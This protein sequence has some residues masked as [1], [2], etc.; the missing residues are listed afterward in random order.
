MTGIIYKGLSQ[1]D[2][3]RRK[4]SILDF[5]L[6]RAKRIVPALLVLCSVLLAVGWF[7]QLSA[8]YRLLGMHSA[9]S[10]AFLS[11]IKYWKE[12]GYFDTESH[13]KWLLHTW[14]LSVEWQFYL[15]L[16]LLMLGLWKLKSGKT[17]M[18]ILFVVCSIASLLASIVVTKINPSAAFYLLPT[19]AW[20][21]LAGGLV[22]LLSDKI[23]LS[24]AKAKLVESTGI[25]FL[26]YSIFAYDGLVPWPSW[27]ALAPVIGSALVLLAARQESIWTGNYTAQ[28]LGTRSY[29]IYLWHWPIWVALGYMQN[30]QNPIYIALGLAA[31]LFLG[32]ISYLFIEEPFRKHLG[33]SSRVKT[34]TV[35]I[36]C[37]ATVSAIGITIR[38]NEGFLGRLS[39]A[40]TNI[41]KESLNFNP[42]RPECLGW[43]SHTSPS[44]LY[45]G[46]TIKA[47]VVGDSHS[48]TVITAVEDA[49]PNDSDGVIGISYS[50]CP[51]IFGVK[52]VGAEKNCIKFNEWVLSEITKLPTSVPVI[53]VNRLT[54]NIYGANETPSQKNT[55][56]I[57]FSTKHKDINDTFLSE[58][59]NNV[60]STTCLLAKTRKVYILRP[61]P[62]MG[63][64]VPK[65]MA[66]STMNGNESEV[67]I[68]LSDYNIR[69][70]FT[71]QTL[72]K[73]AQK[74]GV[75]ILDPAPYLCSND[76]CH[77]EVDGVPLY[78]DDNHLSE[79]G[80]RLLIPMFEK[81]L[82]EKV[83]AEN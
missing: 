53:I 19:R 5:Y 66:L 65:T 32:H 23:S 79:K 58:V 56:Q 10:L 78:A 48:D 72:D 51:T 16:P 42:R 9:M 30:E 35:L 59:E 33:N 17:P 39:E 37:V 49:L 2:I 27:N 21:M 63:V 61:I 36:V 80:N 43:G 25:L 6:S 77:G 54:S 47:V 12:A 74:C 68:A 45:G 50:G 13:E 38:I 44:C 83:S 64:H 71:N 31:T 20:E 82:T 7:F 81:V 46:D 4:F 11:N 40:T 18:T 14:S 24:V 70:A 3:N 28:W 34:S 69:H 26:I 8:D 55:P 52:K 60:I 29:S 22:F 62:E 76:R 15:L 57:Y 73:A 1:A 67:S 41:E 75:V